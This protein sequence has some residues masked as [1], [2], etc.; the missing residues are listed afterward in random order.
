LRAAVTRTATFLNKKLTEEGMLAMLDH[1]S[2]QSM[3]NN[4]AVNLEPVLEYRKTT[5]TEEQAPSL[6]A[7][8]FI[9]KGVIGDWANHMTPEMAK[10]FDEWNAEHLEGTGLTF[11]V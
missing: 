10:K 7:P 5:M 3:K 9:R 11:D 4:P 2:F 6:Q 8:A 1:L